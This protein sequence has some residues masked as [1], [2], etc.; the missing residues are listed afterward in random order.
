MSASIVN[1]IYILPAL[2]SYLP[3]Q[4]LI[5]YV[6]M[7]CMLIG[8]WLKFLKIISYAVELFT[9]PAKY[10]HLEDIVTDVSKMTSDILLGIKTKI[11]SKIFHVF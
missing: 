11:N 6:F 4:V 3:L 8:G 1:I 9:K 5:L 10:F 7:I 2:C